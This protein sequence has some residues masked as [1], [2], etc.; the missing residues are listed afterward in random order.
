MLSPGKKG[1]LQMLLA[2]PERFPPDRIGTVSFSLDTFQSALR[3]LPFRRR[4][5]F[6]MYR[7]RKGIFLWKM[8]QGSL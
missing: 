7:I 8:K 3:L 4:A 6:I 1:A 5:L 2:F